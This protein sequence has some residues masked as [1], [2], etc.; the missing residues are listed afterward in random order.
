MLKLPFL[1]I[2]QRKKKIVSVIVYFF[3]INSPHK[4][5]L[6]IYLKNLE[7]SDLKEKFFVIKYSGLKILYMTFKTLQTHHISN[8]RSIIK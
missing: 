8:A 5:K 2:V 3:K 1:S 6:I 4:Y 7:F